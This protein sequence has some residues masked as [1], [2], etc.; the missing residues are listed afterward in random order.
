MIEITLR[1]RTNIFRGSDTRQEV[2]FKKQFDPAKTAI[3][4]CDMWDFHW[5]PTSTNRF[6]RIAHEMSI[7]I[8][9]ARNQGFQI[10]HSPSDCMDFYKDLP[11]RQGIISLP[12]VQPPDPLHITDPPLPIDA[13][14]DGCEDNPSPKS[15][16]AW[17]RQ[18][19]AIR[20]AEED[21][22]SDNGDEVY[23]FFMDARIQDMFIMG[24]A[25]NMCILGRTFAIRQMTNWGIN[26]VL[27]RD[28]TD[29]MYN[30][31]MPPYVSHDEGTELVVQHIEK[32]W[33]P[34]CLS[35][36]LLL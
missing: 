3:L 11:Q 12:C 9:A 26:C 4:I 22:I 27:V 14:D 23:S 18:H 16:R 32:Y 20:I 24:V 17:T 35:Q 13:S 10:I 1:T 25:V 2:H 5:C 6:N 29:S 30:P 8:E 7:V 36:E 31:K 21:L 15:Y 19:D 33:C 28:M 34:S